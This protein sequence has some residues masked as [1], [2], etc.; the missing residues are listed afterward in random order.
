MD[1]AKASVAADNY[2][3]GEAKDVAPAAIAQVV[4]GED[5]QSRQY[6]K[7]QIERSA[8]AGG[9]IMLLVVRVVDLELAHHACHFKME[10]LFEVVGD[11]GLDVRHYVGNVQDRSTVIQLGRIGRSY[12]G[13]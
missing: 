10:L 2:V 9:V 4:V 13:G 5:T 12:R 7:I 3:G 11:L 1:G 6:L 8:A